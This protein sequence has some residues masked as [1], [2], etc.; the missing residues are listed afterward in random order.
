[1]QGKKLSCSQ[2]RVDRNHGIND[3]L[4]FWSTL[5]S[6]LTK[7]GSHVELYHLLSY[8]LYFSNWS[9]LSNHGES[10]FLRSESQNYSVKKLM[11]QISLQL[12]ISFLLWIL[13]I[14]LF[15][16]FLTNFS[17]NTLLLDACYFVSSH[18]GQNTFVCLL[19]LKE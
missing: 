3:G 4:G 6:E 7:F 19:P 10:I 13:D 1:M 15:N 5:Y 9:C 2:R 18:Q 17:L 16:I 11:F 12:W 14:F 8:I